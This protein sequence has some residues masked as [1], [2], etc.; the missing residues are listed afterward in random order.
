LIDRLEGK[1]VDCATP[2]QGMWAMIVASAAQQSVASGQAVSIDG[3][4][5]E[6]DLETLLN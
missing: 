3:F 1:E 5:A 2:M 4:I 6:N